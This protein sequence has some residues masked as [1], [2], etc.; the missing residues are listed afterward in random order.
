METI[1][2]FIRVDR[3]EI[4]FLKFVLEACEGIATMRT[5]DGPSGTILFSISPGCEH[6]A[7]R[8]LRDLEREIMMESVVPGKEYIRRSHEY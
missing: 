6:E 8:V 7:D 5:I 4:A 1:K 2:K 3:R